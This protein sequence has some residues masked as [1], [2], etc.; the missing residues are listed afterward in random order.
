MKLKL[1]WAALIFTLSAHSVSAEGLPDIYGMAKV[2]LKP[3]QSLAQFPRFTFIENTLELPD[4]RIVATSVFDGRLYMIENGEKS[5]LAEL[6][7][8]HVL[9]L[10][11]L[12]ENL[13]LTANAPAP[14]ESSNPPAWDGVV[15]EGAL[16]LVSLDGQVKELA[17]LPKVSFANGITTTGDGLY[18]IAATGRGEIYFYDH[19]SGKTGL[20][21]KDPALAP[22]TAFPMGVNGLRFRDGKVYFANTG[23]MTLGRIDYGTKEVEI[24]HEG[25]LVDDFAVDG[26][27]TIFGATHAYNNVVAFSKDGTRTIIADESQGAT[28]STSVRFDSTGNLLVSTGGNANYKVL[29]LD[30]SKAVPS[31]VLKITM[32]PR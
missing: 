26:D 6:E 28:G 27:G 21:L 3:T 20:W 15:Y 7:H 19:E 14:E 11:L 17:R 1:I 4:G 31:H 9:C 23:Q 18:L 10:E 8:T 2:D 24:L 5:V 12:G 30:K 32:K 29:G 22:G 13:I 16:L 25:A